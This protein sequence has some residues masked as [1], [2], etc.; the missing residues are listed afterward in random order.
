M[1]AEEL[2]TIIAVSRKCANDVAIKIPGPK[3]EKGDAG[4]DGRDGIDGNDGRHGV[5]GRDGWNGVDGKNGEVGPRGPK[6]DPGKDGKDGR[7]GED[8]VGVSE[9]E[10][11][12][13]VLKVS[14]TDGRSFLGD[15]KGP[16]GNKGDK[17]DQGDSRYVYVGGGAVG[18]GG[19]DPDPEPEPSGGWTMVVPEAA[20]DPLTGTTDQT[21]IH[22]VTLPALLARGQLKGAVTFRSSE[23]PEEFNW[24]GTVWLGETQIAVITSPAPNWLMLTFQAQ[25]TADAAAVVGL[26]FSSSDGVR[27]AV[28]T[29]DYTQA[30]DLTIRGQLGDGSASLTVDNFIIEYLPGE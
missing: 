10:I 24:E 2:A 22:T 30:V 19:G 4:L 1:T 13:G 3:G 8:G 26:G 15:V 7:D 21:I 6:G 11:R 25:I 5:D 9:V 27:D 29:D 16:K 14:L 23:T 17:G 12:N 28:G 18:G 20:I